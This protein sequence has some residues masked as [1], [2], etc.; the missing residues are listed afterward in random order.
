MVGLHAF[1]PST[2]GSIESSFIKSFPLPARIAEWDPVR[3][4]GLRVRFAN[5]TASGRSL[6]LASPSK[7]KASVK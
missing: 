1:F 5:E 4:A 6:R 3:P 2:L 7:E